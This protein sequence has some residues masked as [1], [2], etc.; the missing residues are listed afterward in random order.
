MKNSKKVCF[1]TLF[2]LFCAIIFS[3][4]SSTGG[5]AV[6]A[7][8]GPGTP[9]LATGE[10]MVYNDQESDHG[11][12]TVSL[13]SAEE[14][15][16]GK[17]VMVHHVTGNVTTKFKYGFA[18]WGLN[19]DEA[20]TNLYKTAKK[21]SFWILGD[22]QRYT[23]K[24]KTSNVTDYAYFEYSFNTEKGA[25]MFVEVPVKYFMQPSWG[26]PTIMKQSLVTGIEWQTHEVWRTDPNKNPFDIKMWDFTVYN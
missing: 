8:T 20:T 3:C 26:T 15:I 17:K 22:G 4:G 7:D 11:S 2:A 10:W 5:K 18:G 23:I 21:F 9:T 1:L 16:D 14:T 24:F 12:S 6:K 19:A 13:K 25:P